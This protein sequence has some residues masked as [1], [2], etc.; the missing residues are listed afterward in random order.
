MESLH[1]EL[2]A[3]IF[4]KVPQIFLVAALQTVHAPKAQGGLDQRVP[5]VYDA[6]PQGLA[7]LRY[8]DLCWNGL[9]LRRLDH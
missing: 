9:Q 4:S 7:R 1:V 3:N 8:T 6:H 5:P 2:T